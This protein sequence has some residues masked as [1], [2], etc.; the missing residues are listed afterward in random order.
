MMRRKRDSKPTPK[1]PISVERSNCVDSYGVLRTGHEYS[2]FFP[3][4]TVSRPHREVRFFR[5]L[6]PL[7]QGS[8]V[9]AKPCAIMM[10][11]YGVLRTPYRVLLFRSV[12]WLSDSS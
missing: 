8:S 11:I 5:L 2:V 4:T 3:A 1:H 12:C 7:T 9:G 10:G 6:L